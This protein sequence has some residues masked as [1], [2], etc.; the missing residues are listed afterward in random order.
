VTLGVVD[1][2]IKEEDFVTN[3]LSANTHN[4]LLF[5]TNR[6]KAYQI[7]MYELPEGKRATR[8]KSIMNFLPLG[9]DEKITSILPVPK[10]SKGKSLSIIFITRAGVAKKVALADFEDVRRSGI[11]AIKL[12]A[13][14]ALLSALLVNS[15]DEAIVAS[16]GGQAIRFKE[17]DIRQMGR[18]A[19][20]V[21]AIKLG[22]SD[23]VVGAGIIAPE[24]KTGSILVM[25]ENGFGKMTKLTEYKVQNRGGSGIKTAQVTSKTGKVIEAKVI[26][27]PEVEIV[28]IS[29]QSQVIRTSL[30]DIPTLGRQ[31][32]GVK[33]MKLRPGDALAS[34]TL[35]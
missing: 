30:S 4:D 15:G 33:I 17:K 35:L 18:A 2:N 28:A 23:A 31:T 13:G 1:L 6:G 34:V 25:M 24:G 27:N 21:R 9:D 29:K 14:D 20:G 5:F 8:G 26:T 3:F 19:A 12:S 32:Q 10:T 7:K 16:A 22:K 11:I